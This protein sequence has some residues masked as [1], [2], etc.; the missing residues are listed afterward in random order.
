MA[1]LGLIFYAFS[2]LVELNK[3]LDLLLGHW[4]GDESDIDFLAFL[5][6]TLGAGGGTSVHIDLDIREL[7][8]DLVQGDHEA[9]EEESWVIKVDEDE[10]VWLLLLDRPADGVDSG[11]FK[12]G[13]ITFE[14]ETLLKE[15]EEVRAGNKEAL[16]VVTDWSWLLWLFKSL[17]VEV[18]SVRVHLFD[19]HRGDLRW[20]AENWCVLD[21]LSLNWGLSSN[22]W[23]GWNNENESAGLVLGDEINWPSKLS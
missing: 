13:L 12:E 9:T 23:R 6:H 2:S 5:E 16:W 4:L 8:E 22:E 3:V 15:W 20:S 19:T 7:L 1:I 14:S 18:G 11:L 17:R 10:P 21:H